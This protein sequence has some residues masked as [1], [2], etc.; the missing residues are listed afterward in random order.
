M[1]GVCP[2]QVSLHAGCI[3]CLRRQRLDCRCYAASRR[4]TKRC[5]G[6]GSTNGLT[7]GSN[8][9]QSGIPEES[10]PQL[11]F[12]YEIRGLRLFLWPSGPLGCAIPRWFTADGET[13]SLR[14]QR[15]PGV[16]GLRHQE[17]LQSQGRQA[18]RIPPDQARAE[19]DH[20]A[21]AERRRETGAGHVRRAPRSRWS[22]GTAPTSLAARAKASSET[23]PAMV[24]PHRRDA[25][26]SYAPAGG[27]R[28]SRRERRLTQQRP[29]V[30][31]VR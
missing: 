6:S 17:H 7:N 3:G 31:C 2:Q 22:K 13:S 16:P 29:L 11:L 4:A 26:Q 8:E 30:L 27:G 21:G 5:G 15:G 18:S 9:D 10:E 24:P 25:G 19:G 12:S 28:Q 14:P 1:C 20:A 23:L